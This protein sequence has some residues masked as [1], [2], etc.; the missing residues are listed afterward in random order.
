THRRGE[1][2]RGE[3]RAGVRALARARPAAA[4]RQRF[5]GSVDRPSAGPPHLG[6]VACQLAPPR[7]RPPRRGVRAAGRD[8]IGWFSAG[9]VSELVMGAISNRDRRADGCRPPPA[10]ARG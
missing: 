10:W 1:V 4:A 5:L 7:Y 9:S 2:P 3:R 8:L 6:G